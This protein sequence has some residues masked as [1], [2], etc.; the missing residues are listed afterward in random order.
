VGKEEGEK[1]G[2]KEG[3]QPASLAVG[4][5]QIDVSGWSFDESAQIQLR[6]VA[7]ELRLKT[8]YTLNIKMS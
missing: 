6:P 3:E 5:L 4:Q 1:E 8:H 2:A 7:W